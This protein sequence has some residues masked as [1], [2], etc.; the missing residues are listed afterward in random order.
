LI[1]VR[2]G[3]RSQEF[4]TYAF[5]E[6]DIHANFHAFSEAA[7]KS[8]HMMD[9]RIGRGVALNGGRRDGNGLDGGVDNGITGERDWALFR[10]VGA[11]EEDARIGH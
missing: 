10:V 5:D 9:E 7:A 3:L 8:V 1:L 4:D 11:G 6:V 2:R